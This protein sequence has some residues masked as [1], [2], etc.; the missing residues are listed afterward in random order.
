MPVDSSKVNKVGT[1]V[2]GDTFK[3]MM[4]DELC[5]KRELKIHCSCAK[6]IPTGD[7]CPSVL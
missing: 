2:Y 4:F 7:A 5:L 1:D 6:D 3:L